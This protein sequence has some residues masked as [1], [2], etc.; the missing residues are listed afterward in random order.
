MSNWDFER[1]LEL[2]ELPFIDLIFKAHTVHR[3][4][5]KSDEVQICTLLSIKTGTC[6]EDCAYCPQSAHYET[7]VTKEKLMNVDT[8]IKEATLA[9]EKGATRFCMGAAWRSP[10]KRAM[11]EM[12]KII[13]AVK[14]L[15]LET[16]VTL[17][18][19]NEEEAQTLSD[20]GLDYYNHNLDTSREFYPKIITTRTYDERLQTLENVRK[21]GMHVCCGGILGLGESREDRIQ[22]L[23]QLANLP[24]PP[25]SVPINRLMAI[26]GT[27]LENQKKIDH[28][29]FIRTIAIA[30]IMMPTSFVRLSAGRDTMSDE[31]HAFCFMAGANSI[32]S[33][34]KLLTTP[35]PDQITDGQL[36]AKL[37]LKIKKTNESAHASL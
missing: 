30:R 16:C 5:F 27:P 11:P 6:P 9:K 24:K 2:Y 4:H 23:I 12:V 32:F 33:G 13:K 28:F 17:G 34:D 36:F 3:A 8:I 26:K 14:N 29:E 18:M 37:G 35:N 19:L 1:V 21:A 15:G 10:P 20:A 7:N 25:E 22:L 31:M